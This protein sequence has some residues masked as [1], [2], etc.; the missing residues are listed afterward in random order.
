M[1]HYDNAANGDDGAG[2]A[3]VREAVKALHAAA[4][5]LKLKR[6]CIN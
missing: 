4:Q 6:N 1:K 2:P 3:V 5:K